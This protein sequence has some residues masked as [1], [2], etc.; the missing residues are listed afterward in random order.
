MKT[1]P[2]GE[3]PRLIVRADDFGICHGINVATAR[4]LSEGV[5]TCA[6]VIVP[7]PWFPE[8]AAIC[9][10]HPEWDI[11]VELALTSEWIE[12]RWRPVSPLADVRSLVDEDGYFHRTTDAFLEARPDIKEVEKELRAQLEMAGRH[13]IRPS[14]F[15]HHMGASRRTP[16]LKALTDQLA[17]EYGAVNSG[18]WGENRLRPHPAGCVVPEEMIGGWIAAIRSAQPGVNLMVAHLGTDTPEMQ[19]LH[20][21]HNNHCPAGNRSA[22]LAA[23]TDPCVRHA[24]EEKGIELIGYRQL[25][26]D[27]NGSGP[28]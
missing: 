18:A 4:G 20:I 15:D 13:G 22:C 26:E 21:A 17:E 24:I 7:G 3:K 16:E 1:N 12:M 27:E 25:L 6:G 11:G 19:A 14:F 28:S 8:A 10:A 2:P 5:V 9:R 23:V